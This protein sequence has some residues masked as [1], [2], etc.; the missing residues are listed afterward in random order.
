MPPSD[1][2]ESVAFAEW[3]RQRLCAREIVEFAPLW[4]AP[5]EQKVYL[6]QDASGW[7]APRTS[8]ITL[9]MR[10][11]RQLHDWLSNVL[12]THDFDGRELKISEGE[13]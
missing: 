6:R 13:G 9:G 10:Q 12:A 5:Y 3:L 4:F 7:D 8:R 2:A 1:A 11:A